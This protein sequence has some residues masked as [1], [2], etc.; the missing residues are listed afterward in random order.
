MLS[1]TYPAQPEAA[2]PE[3]TDPAPVVSMGRYFYFPSL[4]VGD[5]LL[6]SPPEATGEATL[7]PEALVLHFRAWPDDLRFK[8]DRTQLSGLAAW[9]APY[10]LRSPAQPLAPASVRYRYTLPA[11]ANHRVSLFRLSKLATQL[12][13]NVTITFYDARRQLL[14]GYYEVRAL[15]QPDPTRAAGPTCTILL[16]GDFDNVKLTLKAV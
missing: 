7:T 1:S 3:S 9:A 14:S 11:T 6:H 16:A 4:G 5:S 2:S 15:N 13:G 12:T 10:A 8:L